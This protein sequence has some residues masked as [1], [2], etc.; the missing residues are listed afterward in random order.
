[1]IGYVSRL[2]KLFHREEQQRKRRFNIPHNQILD[3][4]NYV[5][6][7]FGYVSI[8]QVE[9]EL[10]RRSKPVDG[11]SPNDLAGAIGSALTRLAEKNRLHWKYLDGCR[12]YYRELVTERQEPG[13]ISLPIQS[14]VVLSPQPEYTDREPEAGTGYDWRKRYRPAISDDGS[15]QADILVPLNGSD[16]MEFYSRLSKWDEQL[17]IVTRIIRNG[18]ANLNK[19]VHSGASKR[20][21]KGTRGYELAHNIAK[22]IKLLF[23]CYG[24]SYNVRISKPSDHGPISIELDESIRIKLERIFNH[25]QQ[26]K[27]HS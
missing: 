8:P 1:M 13:E 10:R 11:H 17:G 12:I 21:T 25:L 7:K 23:R 5:I 14:E 15:G 2:L 9:E 24:M 26:I 19:D 18:Y 20:G 4:A 27:K 3:A 22:N 6:N 16:P